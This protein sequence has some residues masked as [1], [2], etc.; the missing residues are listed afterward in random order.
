MSFLDNVSFDQ[1]IDFASTHT[2]MTVGIILALF[3]GWISLSEA[4]IYLKHR[5]SRDNLILSLTGFFAGLVLIIFQDFLLG[6][7]TSFLLLVLIQTYDL[8]NTPIWYE[9]MKATA[10]TYFVTWAGWV[11]SMITGD[12]RIFGFTFNFS[13]YV[14]LG[15]AFYYF[16]KR[17]ILVSRI[18]SP[19][20]LYLTIFGIAYIVILKFD[21]S[22]YYAGDIVAI[23]FEFD[24]DGTPAQDLTLWQL[25]AEAVVYSNGDEIENVR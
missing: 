23:K 22:N 7:L 15:L 4:R 10:A 5:S 13:I 19:Q 25:V 17:F 16:G 18:M 3:T 8:R 24:A 11:A 21:I 6:I 9:L 14:F 1:I 12:G 2:E 20:V